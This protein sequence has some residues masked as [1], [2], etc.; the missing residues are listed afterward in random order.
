MTV[1]AGVGGGSILGV[2][3]GGVA[4]GG[5]AQAAP[6]GFT[7]GGGSVVLNHVAGPVLHPVVGPVMGQ[8]TPVT[9]AHPFTGGGGF[10]Q[11]TSGAADLV[12]QLPFTGASHLMQLIGLGLFLLVA[13]VL[14]TGLA[15]RRGGETVVASP[16]L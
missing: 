3:I 15:N 8:A 10:T 5:G 16:A 13:G 4:A 12:H 1:S 7:G 9:S 14:L 11:V 2:L 6:G